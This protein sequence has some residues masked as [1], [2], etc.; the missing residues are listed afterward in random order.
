[1]SKKPRKEKRGDW[2]VMGGREFESAYCTRCGQG[3]TFQPG[4]VEAIV[5][6]MKAFVIRH[7]YCQPGPVRVSNDSTSLPVEPEEA[8]ATVGRSVKTLAQ[9]LARVAS[10]KRRIRGPAKNHSD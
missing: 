2:V 1:M 7:Q 5:M 3:W 9:W 4:P 10:K 8:A 6:E